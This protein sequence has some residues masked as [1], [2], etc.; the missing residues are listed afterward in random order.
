MIKE[1]RKYGKEK[2][3]YLIGGAVKIGKLHV[4]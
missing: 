2:T 4:I 1:G 3:I